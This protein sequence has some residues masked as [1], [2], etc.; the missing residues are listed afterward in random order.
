MLERAISLRQPWAS[1]M[2]HGHK[3]IE[4]R[5]WPTKFEGPLLIHAS[6]WWRRE[7]IERDWALSLSI[8]E[9][10]GLASPSFGMDEMR[11]ARGGVIGRMTVTGCLAESDDPFFFGP[12]GFPT[13]DA[14]ALDK[15]VACRGMLGIFAVPKDVAQACHDLMGDVQ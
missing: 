12:Y 10:A 5:S 14:H 4:N 8:L 6:L 3:R 7:E 9:N 15:V 1:L 13:R 2:A 11:A